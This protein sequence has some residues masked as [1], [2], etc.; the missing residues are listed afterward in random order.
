MSKEL[1]RSMLGL[2]SDQITN[3]LSK[4][5]ELSKVKISV[6]LINNS[7]YLF[8]LTSPDDSIPP[9]HQFVTVTWVELV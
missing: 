7:T 4:S 3:H 5:E 6:W 9:H 8:T 2:Y 1:H